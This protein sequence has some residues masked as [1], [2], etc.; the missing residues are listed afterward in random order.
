MVFQPNQS[1]CR[2]QRLFAGA[3]GAIPVGGLT[4]AGSTLYGATRQG[5]RSGN[6]VVFSLLLAQVSLQEQPQTQT[7][8]AGGTVSL[9]ADA[10]ANPGLTYQWLFNGTLLPNWT[11]DGTLELANLQF[12]QSGSYSVIV[13]S[14]LGAVTSSPA[15]LDIIPPVPRRLVPA[16][17]VTGHLSGTTTY[18]ESTDRL[19][20]DANWQTIA[21]IAMTNLSQFCFD[22]TP[23][24]S[25]RFY[26]GWQT[27]SPSEPVSLAVD[28]VTAIR[29]TGQVGD[30]L[31][32]DY[33][34]TFGPTGAWVTLA[35]VQLTSASQLY[36]DTSGI[37]QPAR[38]YRIVPVP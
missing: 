8:E 12:S 10:G 21:L 17:K 34:D 32:L 36:F 35:T 24:A 16:I 31:R 6:G 29:L 9:W 5:G 13:S 23:L 3:D 7:A 11:P 19:G 1:D 20:P 38:L 30:S 25:R 14:P 37:G 26:R 22:L 18:L 15:I 4:L 27:G 33:V 28:L 2:G